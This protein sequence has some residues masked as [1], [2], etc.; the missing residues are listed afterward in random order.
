[1]KLK[2][3]FFAA[4]LLLSMAAQAQMMPPIP[5][6]QKVRMGKLP[7][8]LTYYIRQNGWPEKRVNFYIAQRV[9]SIQEN[10]DQ[11]GLAHFLEHMA[12]N[13]TENFK[14]N[15][16]IEYT[17]SLG[18][19]FGRDLNA[20]TSID[21]TVYNINDVP[22]NRISALDS[23]LLILKDWSNGLLLETHE[24]DQ[25]RGVIHEEWRLRSSASQRMFERNLEKLY[26]G[27][28]Y[29]HRM[30]IG[31]MEIIDNFK[32][33]VLRDYYHKWYHPENQA[34]IVVGDIDVDRTEQK[35]KEMFSG[36][37]LSENRGKVEKEMV[38]DTAEPIII[39]DKD[40][41]QQNNV[42]MVMF[43]HEATPDSEKGSMMYLIEGYLKQ[44]ACD[45]LNQRLAE[46][47]LEADCPYIQAS[48]DDGQFIFASTK[49]CFEMT[50]LP[51]EGRTEEALATAFREAQRAMQF[52][53]TATEYAR[54]RS[55][56]LSRLEKDYTNR[57]K[58]TNATYGNEYT[59][60][61]LNNEPIPSMDDYYAIMNQIVPNIPVEAI[62]EVF[63]QLISKNDSNLIVINFNTEKENATY[64]T[65]EGFLKAI[66]GVR[67]E[68]LT[69]YVDNV[70]DEPLLNTLPK[71]GKIK[72]EKENK[73]L[74]YKE[75]T[76]SNGARVILK[77]TN[78]KDDEIQ[79]M[80]LSK[81]GSSLLP[82]SDEIN[83]KLINAVIGSSGLGNFDN[84]E[85]DKALAGKQ[86]SAEFGLSNLHES[87]SGSCVPKDVETMM[88]LTYLKFTNIKKDEKAYN[89]L[90]SMLENA[91]KNKSLSPESAFSDSVSATLYK[92]NPRFMS[93]EAEDLKRLN[94][95]RCLQ[96]AKERLANAADFTFYFV[97]NFDENTLRPLI[98]QYIASLPGNAKKKENWKK[99]TTYQ[100]GTAVNK[101][102]R[103][104]E[105]P[106]ARAMMYWYNNTIPYSLENAILASAAGQVLDM[107]YIKK[108]REEA[109]AAYS[110]G[111]GGSVQLGGDMPYNYLVGDCPMKPEMA[112]TALK[113]MREEARNLTN[114][115]DADMLTKIKEAMIKNFETNT[116]R[117]GYWMDV[118]SDYDELG[119]DKYTTYR[120]L[121]EGVTPEKVAQFVKN[122]IFNN[123]NTVEVVMLPEEAK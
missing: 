111:A 99:V 63:P 106:K 94:Y 96:I 28:K 29:G 113:I 33:Q 82:E 43:K 119:V 54:T 36:I 32:P 93:I 27:S 112:E 100:Q 56:Y 86:A 123:T 4:L 52:G 114:T 31:K 6:D 59:R 74:G 102:Y 22:S 84:M 21:E 66:N 95:D 41:E 7:N 48:C 108:I 105:T 12:F 104:M 109:S 18:V 92:H 67:T 68:T 26:P 60:H 73:A 45:M 78:Y 61:Y 47:S 5:V 57:N 55:E 46:K 81:G 13:G 98:E 3:I 85:L 58:I 110:A 120:K 39:I 69:A 115:V 30:P 83:Y 91:L 71:K 1:M 34:I 16:V 118:I 117:N 88:Q 87:I 62:N 77:Q 8:G 11:R 89:T 75:L 122:V 107:I 76:L 90:I 101:F 70:K 20:Y 72:S 37:K 2:R 103:K 116:K 80:A 38:P 121:V 79:M 24:I 10:D 14:G 50:I 25:E 40:K 15:G 64:P 17:R 53:F 97:G 44:L 49:D 65:S 9:G 23:C 42:I 19:E 35:I 51:K